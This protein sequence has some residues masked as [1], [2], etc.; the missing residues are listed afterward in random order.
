MTYPDALQRA[1]APGERVIW[2]RQSGARLYRAA[3]GL[4][5]LVTGLGSC[6]ALTAGM[7]L[8]FGI[9]EGAT[10]GFYAV[11]TLSMIA[12]MAM[13][14]LPWI[15]HRIVR[16][17]EMCAVT[18]RRAVLVLEK[19]GRPDSVTSM[20]P[21]E[22]NRLIGREYAD[23]SGN[24][25]LSFNAKTASQTASAAGVSMSVPTGFSATW[26]G[27]FDVPDVRGACAAVGEVKPLSADIRP[28]F[29]TR[30]KRLF[31]PARGIGPRP[32]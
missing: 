3:P 21:A 11:S 15:A 1:I 12:S 25:Y 24:V 28:A 10:A 26:K 13:G 18:D 22:I 9:T 31:L 14:T 29:A 6:G 27:F 32:A 7:L 23:G 19:P 17:R 8:Y 16:G 20:S 2:W 5:L 4:C 30:M